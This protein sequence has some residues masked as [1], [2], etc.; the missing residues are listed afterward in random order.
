M[1]VSDTATSGG[2]GEL[3][4]HWEERVFRELAVCLGGSEL[5][6]IAG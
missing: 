5:T 6:E 3:L 4:L 2:C 1:E